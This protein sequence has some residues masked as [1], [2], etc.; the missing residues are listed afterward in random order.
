MPADGSDV[1]ERAL[2]DQ[3]F[4]WRPPPEGPPEPPFQ[5]PV[6]LE[7]V[8]PVDLPG[9]P[10]DP[11]HRLG[12]VRGVLKRPGLAALPLRRRLAPIR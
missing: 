3:L 10:A 7:V 11:R 9:S 2:I 4:P 1:D 12:R 5:S 6:V 8:P